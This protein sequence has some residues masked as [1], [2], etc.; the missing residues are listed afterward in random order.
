M[1]ETPTP[2]G[3]TA[4]STGKEKRSIFAGRKRECLPYD[5]TLR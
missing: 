2:D 1:R 5:G 3:I 4:A